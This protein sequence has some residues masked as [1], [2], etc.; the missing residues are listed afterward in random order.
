M[1]EAAKNALGI[2]PEGVLLCVCFY[3]ATPRERSGESGMRRR[4]GERG[5]TVSLCRPRRWLLA[6]LFLDHVYFQGDGDG[7]GLA[8]AAQDVGVDDGVGEA[9]LGS[10]NFYV[11]HM[12]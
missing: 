3:H 5:L 2:I 7:D 1:L 9:F 6:C 8:H 11:S 10:E 12:V 4:G